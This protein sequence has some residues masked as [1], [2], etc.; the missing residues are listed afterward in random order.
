MRRIGI[1]IGRIVGASAVVLLLS[2]C[3]SGDEPAVVPTQDATGPDG[4]SAVA[5]TGPL[6]V[7]LAAGQPVAA[8]PAPLA[9]VSG[10]ELTGERIAEILARLPGFVTDD[11]DEQAFNRP[12]ASLRPPTVGT[13]DEVPFG[14]PD[15]GTPAP[16]DPGPLEVVRHQ[17]DGDVD[18]APFLSVTFNQDVIPVGTLEQLDATAAPVRVTPELPGRWRWIGTRTLRY[19]HVSD[20]LDRLPAATEYAVEVP[21]GTVSVDGDELTEPYRWTFRTPAATVAS[22]VPTETTSLPLQPV[23]VTTF[24][25]RVDP[26]AVLPTVVVTAD[27]DPQPLRLATAAEIDA[28]DVARQAWAQALEGRAVAFRVDGPLPPDARIEVAVGP[29]TPSAEGPRT[30]EQAQRFSARTFGAFR[31]TEHECGYGEPCRPGN[32]FVLSFSNPIDGATFDPEAIRIDPALPDAAIAVSHSR[33]FIQGSTRAD[34][35]YRVTVPGDLRDIFDQ[36]LG[37]DEMVTFEVGQPRPELRPFAGALTVV[38]PLATT[39]SVSVTSVGHAQLRTR[40][41]AVTAADWPAF[42]TWF[43]AHARGAASEPP[44]WPVVVDRTLDSGA[45]PDGLPV[46]TV[47]DLR[48]ALDGDHG[49]IVVIVEPAVDAPPNRDD[50]WNNRPTATWAQVTSLGVDAFADH[51]RLVT[52]VTRLADGTP[53]AQATVRA[54]S[55]VATTDEDGLA[56]LPLSGAT[57]LVASVGDEDVI[58]GSSW[59]QPWTE[60]ARDDRL[61]WY[62]LDDRGLYRPGKTLHLKGVVRR[63]R[64]EDAAAVVA[65]GGQP[66]V[67]FQAT[68]PRG[69]TFGEGSVPVSGLGTFDLSLDIPEGA[70]LGRARVSLSLVGAPG[71]PG[72]HDTVHSFRVDEFRRPTFEVVTRE[73]GPGPHRVDDPT[74]VAVAASYLAGGPLTGAPVS[75]TVG[76]RDTSYAPPNWPT[77]TFG[78]WVPWWIVGEAPWALGGSHEFH[79]DICCP[80]PSQPAH[81]ERFEATTDAGGT[82]YLEIDLQGERPDQPVL[83]SAHAS[84]T[85]VDSQQLADTVDLLVHPS[86]YYVGLRTDRTFVREGEQLDVDV[87][88]TTIDGEVTTGREVQVTAAR[89]EHRDDGG[90]YTEV[91]VDEQSCTVTSAA[92]PVSCSFAAGAGGRYRIEAVVRDDDGGH[93]RTE[94]TRWVSGATAIPRRAVQREQL[95]IVPDRRTYAVGDTAH[96]L[97]LA[98]FPAGH[99]LATVTRG[100]IVS[101]ATFALADGSAEVDVPVTDDLVGGAEVQITVDGAAQRL[102]DDGTSD[103]DLPPRPAYAMGSIA[104]PVPPLART[105]AVTAT[106]REDAVTPGDT[107]TLDIAVLGPDGQPAGGAEVAVIVADEAVL[108]LIGRALTDPVDVF[109]TAIASN[110]RVDVVRGTIV[111]SRPADLDGTGGDLDGTGGGTAA[112]GGGESGTTGGGVTFDA[113]EPTSMPASDGLDQASGSTASSE[114]APDADPIALRTDFDPLA[115]FA[116]SVVTGGDGRATVDVTVPDNLT[117][118]RVTAV[119]VHGTDRFGA[120]EASLVARLPL[121]ARPSAPRFLNFG[122]RF[123]FPVVLQNQ[124]DRDLEVDVVLQG[125]NLAVEGAGD[126][127]GGQRVL[128]PGNDRVEVRFPAA[129]DT[130]G[131]ARFRIAAVAGDL[132]DAAAGDLPVYTPVTTEAFATYGVLDGSADGDAARAVSAH[133]LLAPDGV[134]PQFGGLDV[135]TSST[136]L[137][138]LTDAVLYLDRYQYDHADAYAS[139]VLTIV[140][141]RDVLAA[142]DALGDRAQVDATVQDDLDQL[143]GLQHADGGFGYWRRGGDSWPYV[144]VHAAHALIAG[145]DA[146]Y[147]VPDDAI[148]RSLQYLRSIEDQIRGAWGHEP[149]EILIAY[150]L[151][152]RDRAGDRDAARA[153][154]LFRDSDDL[155]LDALAWIWPVVDDPAILSEIDRIV[156]NRVAETPGAAVFTTSYDESAHLVLA[157][158]RR[159]DGLLLDA[160]IRMRPDSDLVPKVVN[161]LLAGQQ[162]GRWRNVQENTF[163]LHAFKRYFDTYEATSPDLVARVWLGDDYVAEHPYPG[164]TID[165]QRSRVPMSE[166]VGGGDRRLVVSNDG[167]G[168]LYYRLGLSYAPDDLVLEARDEGFVV[169]RTYEAIDDPAD[170]RRTE[171]GTWHVRRGANVRVRL[172]MVA[173]HARTNLA[174]VD[175]L[176][177]GLEAVNPAFATAPQIRPDD[178]V[179]EP[180]PWSWGWW[181]WYGHQ[182]LRDDRVEAFASYLPAGT[183]EYTYV[184][185]ATTPGT[186]V[187]PPAKAEELYAP[188][189][190][191]RSAS[192]RVVVS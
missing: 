69:V 151:H 48:D 62:L 64:L 168:R 71:D 24:D 122:D 137:A 87:V 177:A 170:V 53:V 113:A 21:A 127:A 40:L 182:N 93:Q 126:N 110:L 178:T 105:L 124:T 120:V 29:G 166:L 115:L 78:R 174:L 189:V 190:F 97:V 176:P 55:Q 181:R 72:E 154:R 86:G 171:D 152:V 143:V 23:F 25:Q 188:E 52:W 70:N 100:D 121:M 50:H 43:D 101:T 134:V 59:H 44:P 5:A 91:A 2:A 187:T 119:A 22:F 160:L 77:F 191:G 12:T 130:A 99:G 34:T 36:T 76:H 95:T 104:L 89:L 147:R 16:T 179:D 65:I 35:T 26:S 138:T 116:P 156:H 132:S 68:D 118:Y 150:A 54:G 133:E 169:D 27:D 11:E 102:R 186:Y 185:R 111:L 15:G 140:A 46:E 39:P 4:G 173:E 13:T 167:T 63:I 135:S 10:E 162:R 109:H 117:R 80:V 3:P 153:Q 19:E 8:A 155:P 56:T 83:V 98:P 75:W 45:G 41:L 157:S 163:I 74:T 42:R 103:P 184:A 67:R 161:G 142:F 85:D 125:A 112:G 159:T 6:R 148:E 114:S 28:D 31:L 57:H 96:L 106:P 33:L 146:G 158:S 180:G 32:P 47:I 175:P 38:D 172:T 73:E 17:P 30:S 79:G 145:R 149:R 141:L 136:L 81:V 192:D 123:G 84:I 108:S 94:L 7:R 37:S 9:T 107:T 82:H 139:R 164:R 58:L 88:V 66:T 129:A 92:E 14:E 20:D 60:Q 18:V 49:H 131:T 165:G 90:Q 51:R 144:S 1:G 183:F 128:V 61:R